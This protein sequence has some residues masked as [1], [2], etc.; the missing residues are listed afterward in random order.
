MLIVEGFSLL[1]ESRR[2]KDEDTLSRDMTTSVASERRE[3]ICRREG[4]VDKLGCDTV[5]IELEHKDG[6]WTSQR[7]ELRIA[8]RDEA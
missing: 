8:N 4:Q 7:R 1:V 2:Y 6:H 5:R 3:G